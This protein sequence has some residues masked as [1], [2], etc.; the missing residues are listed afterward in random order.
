MKMTFSLNTDGVSIS[1]K[2]KLSM[3]PIYLIIKEHPLHVR[4]AF[5]NVIIAGN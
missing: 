2:S 3:W 5:D 4:F 1:D